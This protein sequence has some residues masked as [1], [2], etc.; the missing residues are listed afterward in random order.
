M[1]K[2][3]LKYSTFLKYLLVSVISFVIDITFFSVFNHLFVNQIIKNTIFARVISST[4]N[5]LLNKKQ[6]FKSEESNIK[7]IIKYFSLVIIQMLIS[8]FLVDNIY[9]IFKNINP[10]FIKI[11]VEFILFICN[12][13][14][15]KIFI[16][17][18]GGAKQ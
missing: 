9:K 10:T 6:V 3:I 16:F 7:T 1:K 4:I 2:I 5:Y 11:P 12:Y 14:I 8:A 15:Q 13:L 17:K 18:K